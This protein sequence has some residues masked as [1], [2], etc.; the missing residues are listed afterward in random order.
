MLCLL[1][2]CRYASEFIDEIV[3]EI[4]VHLLN[5]TDLNVA[6]HPVGIKCRVRD[7]VGAEEDDVHMVGIWGIGGIG[8]TT[9]ARAVYNSVAYK[10]EG[11]CF[12][13]NV[14]E[15]SIQLGGLVKLQNFLLSKIVRGMEVGEQCS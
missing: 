11:G 1:L 2:N 15:E 8:K 7:V 13:E 10:F 12:L 14:G 3:E 4:S 5:L 9:I 6:R